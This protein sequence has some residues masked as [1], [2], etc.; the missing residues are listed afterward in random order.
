M[1]KNIDSVSAISVKK[2]WFASTIGQ[3]IAMALM[4]LSVT[5][6]A[7]PGPVGAAGQDRIPP[8]APTNLRVTDKSS[9]LVSL[10]WNPSSDN[11]GNFSYRIRHSGGYETTL[12]KTQTSY[13]WTSNLEAG[14]TYSFYV[15]AV[16]AAGNKSKPS[17]TVAV[18]LPPDRIPPTTP[19]VSV[20]EV[21]PTHV[22]LSWSSIDDGPYVFYWVF[23]NG[24]PVIQ[25]STA[26]SGTVQPLEPETTYTFRV[27]ARDNGINWSPLSDPVIVTTTPSNPN[28]TTPPTTPQNLQALDASGGE[29]N[30]SWNRSTDNL[31]PQSRIRYDAYVNGELTFSTVDL[32]QSI[33]Y[34]VNGSNTISIIAVDTAGNRSAPAT[35][36]IVI[37]F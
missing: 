5:W 8:A 36:T 14:R 7:V 2:K 6:L 34:G 19:V 4:V 25:G 31:D 26:M 35:T 22:T 27:Q 21:G 33:V 29:I 9:F 10:A 11:S 23:K 17:N 28:D 13:N 15:Y 18:K 24:D 16:D 37:H 12:P 1:E 32:T 3:F 30:I 20:T